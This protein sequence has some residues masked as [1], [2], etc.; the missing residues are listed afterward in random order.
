MQECISS[1]VRSEAEEMKG[2]NTSKVF[3]D[4]DLQL[5]KSSLHSCS[6]MGYLVR[7]ISHATVEVILEAAQSM[8]NVGTK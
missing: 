2:A 3:E 5:S 6:S 4:V 1:A 8:K 7:S